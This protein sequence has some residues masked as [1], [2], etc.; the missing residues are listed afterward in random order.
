MLSENSGTEN[1]VDM[2]NGRMKILIVDDNIANIDVMVSF[3]EKEGYELSIANSGYRA[4]K[5]AAHSL[6]DLILLDVMM[7]DLDGFATCM[8]LKT[9]PETADIPVIFVTARKEL[10]DIV[11]GFRC[12]GVD[13]ITKPF[14]KEEV[15]SR[16]TTHLQIRRMAQ[17][18]ES[19]IQD[20][21]EA[22]HEVKMLR[23]LLPICSYC[24]KIRDEEGN[25]HQLENYL[26]SRSD[27]TFTHTIC[28]D[29][30][31]KIEI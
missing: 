10:D 22:L 7:P 13:Y 26:S 6:P 18:R 17:E 21:E 5:I 30:Y 15:L 16:V 20:L 1:Q 12:G 28:Q 14:R 9:T 8:Q 29:C 2:E 11:E 3:L 19:L 25:W 23:G 27:L 4:I 31:N 24:K